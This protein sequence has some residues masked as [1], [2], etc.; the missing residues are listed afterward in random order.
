MTAK[1]NQISEVMKKF[2]LVSRLGNNIFNELSRK[3]IHIL[4]C[5]LTLIISPFVNI[6]F[7]FVIFI[8]GFLILFLLENNIF[9]K[10]LK[11]V[12]RLSYGHYF[13]LIGIFLAFLVHKIIDTDFSAMAFSFTILTLGFSD[14]AATTGK[15]FVESK[16]AKIFPTSLLAKKIGYKSLF[17]FCMFFLV[18]LIIGF[19]VIIGIIESNIFNILKVI[20]LSFL[21]SIVEL[22]SEL[23][24]D[25]L[26]I[27]LF[28]YLFIYLFY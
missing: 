1:N 5:S 23:G 2:Y 19:S 25:N 20:V 27:P 6:H 10:Y 8:F 18:T 13:M 4:T 9:M 11:N 21:L 14:S 12:N 17:G 22:F 15:Y 24:L 28:S 16:F 26:L 3:I 7:G